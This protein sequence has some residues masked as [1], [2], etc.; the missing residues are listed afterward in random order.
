MNRVYNFGAGPAML[1]TSVMEQAQKDFLDWNGMG[2]SVIEIS[3]K[4][5]CLLL[6]TCC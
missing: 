3:P 6:A 2:C 4:L 1:P 5:C